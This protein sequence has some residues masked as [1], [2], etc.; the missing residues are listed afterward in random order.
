MLAIGQITCF[1]VAFLRNL[2]CLVHKHV[3]V[4]PIHISSF[5]PTLYSL[6]HFFQRQFPYQNEVIALNVSQKNQKLIPTNAKNFLNIYIT[7]NHL[8]TQIILCTVPVTPK[9]CGNGCAIIPNGS[10]TNAPNNIY[11]VNNRKICAA[12][13]SYKW[14]RINFATCHSFSNWPF[15]TYNPIQCWCPGKVVNIL[16]CM[17]TKYCTIHWMASTRYVSVITIANAPVR[18]SISS[19]LVYM[20]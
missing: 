10:A 1:A 4:E 17:A 16:V 3:Y 5:E 7:N 19:A 8:F 2:L 9:N 15:K 13:F 20:T 18:S 12:T 6:Q 11:A 14:N